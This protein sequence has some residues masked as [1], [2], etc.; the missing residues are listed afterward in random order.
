MQQVHAELIEKQV[1][2][3]ADFEQQYLKE[4]QRH[5]ALLK[6]EKDEYEKQL[7][8]IKS[9]FLVDQENNNL[10]YEQEK[11]RLKNQLQQALQASKLYFNSFFKQNLS[12]F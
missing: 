1:K 9:G 7:Q 5:D 8:V 3:H 11:I 4:Q 6:V 12:I 2:Q 10:E